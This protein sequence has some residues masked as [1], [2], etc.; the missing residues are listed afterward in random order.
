MPDK[1]TL[2]KIDISAIS[3]IYI[4]TRNYLLKLVGDGDF[5]NILSS[6]D[7]KYLSM[8]KKMNFLYIST[9]DGRTIYMCLNDFDSQELAQLLKP[10]VDKYERI[11]FRCNDRVICK[12]IPPKRITLQQ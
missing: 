12:I 4:G 5:Y 9:R 3:K 8:L 7:K 6:S 11:D 1:T 10:I 2:K